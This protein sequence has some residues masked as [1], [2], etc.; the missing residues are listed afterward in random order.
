MRSLVIGGAGFIGSH[1]CGAL[2]DA[3][4]IDKAND[5]DLDELTWQ[6][7]VKD[8]LDVV[9]HLAAEGRIQPEFQQNHIDDTFLSTVQALKL[10][11]DS[12]ADHFIFTSSG[13][14]YG[15][16]ELPISVY[17]AC[18]LG[19]EGLVRA[20]GERTGKRI[21]I[22]RLG[23][24][25]GPRCRG[26]IPDILGKLKADPSRLEVCGDGTARKPF[27]HVDDVVKVLLDPPT[28]KN[29]IWDIRP[30]DSTTVYDTVMACIDVAG[31]NCAHVPFPA[32]NWGSKPEG[33][34]GDI[35]TPMSISQ[36][37]MYGAS[38]S[39]YDAMRKAVQEVWEGMK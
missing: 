9:Y 22:L 13:A 30:I 19:A 17:G 3:T 32:I 2:R 35:P 8:G 20:W 25:V 4:C 23:N 11:D 24:V 33:W 38:M 29:N 12:G 36:R 27:V 26:V 5:D 7:D 37:T 31:L 14:V 6:L 16:G 15:D 39:S 18:K 1:L 10:A 34:V 21:S 28:G